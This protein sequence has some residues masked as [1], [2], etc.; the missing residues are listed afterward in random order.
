MEFDAIS[1]IV[2]AM[3]L[4]ASDIPFMESVNLMLLDGTHLSHRFERNQT[5]VYNTYYYIMI[6]SVFER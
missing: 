6:I 4:I 5:V 1:D 2:C 3:S